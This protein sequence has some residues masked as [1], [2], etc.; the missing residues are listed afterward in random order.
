MKIDKELIKEILPHRDP[1]LFI[2]K[3]DGIDCVNNPKTISDLVGGKIFARFHAS[4]NLDV[5]AGHFPGNPV[6]PGV[7]QTEIMAQAA[8]LLLYPLVKNRNNKTLKVALLGIDGARFK[9]VVLPGM[10]LQVENC[11]VRVK[12]G[13][14]KYQGKIVCDNQLMSEAIIMAM[15]DLG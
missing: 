5:F 15:V 4:S 8:C 10:D 3:V 2:D 7:L 9:K 11:C 14:M 12:G 1:F 6:F 13:I